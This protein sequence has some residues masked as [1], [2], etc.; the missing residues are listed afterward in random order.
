MQYRKVKDV[1]FV[2]SSLNKKVLEAASYLGVS[3]ARSWNCIEENGP[4]ELFHYCSDKIPKGFESVRGVV[5]D[6]K[7]NVVVA[8]SYNYT[9]TVVC[10][11]LKVNNGFLHMVD[12]NGTVYHLPEDKFYMK[13]GYEGTVMRVFKH[14][15]KV[16]HSSHRR[17]DTVGSYW[18][19]SPTFLSIY[20]DLGGPK[21]E[22]LFDVD[23]DYSPHCHVFL[24]IH[25][26]LL[27]CSRQN[28]GP[29]YL[30]YLGALKLWEDKFQGEKIDYE[31][32]TFPMVKEIPEKITEPFILNPQNIT[33]EE[34]NKHLK[35][36]WT[37]RGEFIIVYNKNGSEKTMPSPIKI[38]STDYERRS[39]VRSNDPNIYHRFVEMSSQASNMDRKL[40]M[41]VY[42]TT[43]EATLE[44]RYEAILKRLAS[45]L[46]LEDEK[47]CDEFLKRFLDERNDLSYWITRIILNRHLYS[48][49]VIPE[50]ILRVINRCLRFR[51]DPKSLRR[52]ITRSLIREEGGSLYK[53]LRFKRKYHKMQ[54]KKKEKEVQTEKQ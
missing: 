31:L 6:S 39:N 22:E 46:P 52:E 40:F 34:A 11:E 41:E 32:K 16:Y 37:G 17:L 28:V 8:R 15:G 33:L 49:I 48:D 10:D 29:G 14:G 35:E 4:L 38:S 50:N 3:P 43:E 26:S 53:M 27:V 2:D 25:P 47:K 20:N 13:K 42:G 5:F 21:D 30:V 36:G 19:S 45:M 12:A 23:K 9:P 1:Q 24:I 51:R 44:D 7:E 18:G 54:E